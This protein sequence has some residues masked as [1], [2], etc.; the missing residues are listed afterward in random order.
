MLIE[1]EISGRD[2]CLEEGFG[3]CSHERGWGESGGRG[4]ESAHV[5]ARVREIVLAVTRM[6]AGFFK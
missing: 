1:R 4:R 5:R 6:G 2:L 3:R